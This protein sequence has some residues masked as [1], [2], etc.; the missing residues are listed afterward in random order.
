MGRLA[1]DELT[2]P[3]TPV[4]SRRSSQPQYSELTPIAE[5][6]RH[7]GGEDHA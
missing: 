6:V 5:R 3:D 7:A 1:E 2:V 4:P